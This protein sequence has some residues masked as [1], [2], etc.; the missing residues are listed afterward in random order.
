MAKVMS[1][2]FEHLKLENDAF[3]TTAATESFGTRTTPRLIIPDSIRL[4]LSYLRDGEA[5]PVERLLFSCEICCSICL[6]W[7]VVTM[8]YTIRKAVVILGLLYWASHSYPRRGILRQA[9]YYCK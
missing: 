5:H 6:D 7:L 8:T 3:V 4:I 9:D 2:P 1:G